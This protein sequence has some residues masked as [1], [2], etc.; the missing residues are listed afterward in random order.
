[1]LV[2]FVMRDGLNGFVNMPDATPSNEWRRRVSEAMQV[3]IQDITDIG[4][5]IMHSQSIDLLKTY[6]QDYVEATYVRGMELRNAK[7]SAAE[8]S[9]FATKAAMASAY[10][11]NG[12]HLEALFNLA[13]T[14]TK[15]TE[16]GKKKV[17]KEVAEKILSKF[18]EDANFITSL[19]GY[20]KRYL[21]RIPTAPSVA[22][23]KKLITEI[24]GEDPLL[25]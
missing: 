25:Q 4:N 14:D 15:V 21:A 10:L 20:R 3:D 1:M 8:R 13:G 17:A 18:N 6:A 22:D 9:T 24:K 16:A 12:D 19:E 2:Y 5:D 7:Y 23:M 11:A